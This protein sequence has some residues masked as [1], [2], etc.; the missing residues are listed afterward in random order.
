M[1]AM[2]T[3]A[4]VLG[5]RQGCEE[6]RRDSLC[7]FVEAGGE[8]ET[9]DAGAT[10]TKLKNI[11][12]SFSGRLGPFRGPARLLF[13][14]FGWRPKTESGGELWHSTRNRSDGQQAMGHMCIANC[15]MDSWVDEAPPTILA[16]SVCCPHTTTSDTTGSFGRLSASRRQLS[17]N[18]GVHPP[19]F[20]ENPSITC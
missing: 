13:C 17:V 16:C 3:R 10:R 20:A 9:A 5:K 7:G 11:L 6:N 19:H 4:L 15:C 12:R 18:C 1:A 14:S 8:V 2:V